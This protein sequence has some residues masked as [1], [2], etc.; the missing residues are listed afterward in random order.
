[1]PISDESMRIVTQSIRLMDHEQLNVVMQAVAARRGTINPLESRWF[2]GDLVEFN[3]RQGR[4]IKGRIK[5]VNQVTVTLEACTDRRGQPA[6]ERGVRVPFSMLRRTVVPVV[7]GTSIDAG[8]QAGRMYRPG[9][10][11][12]AR[13]LETVAHNGMVG[14][15]DGDEDRL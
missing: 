13:V 11:P 2:R 1:M 10:D 8:M 7:A 14:P 15:Q 12:M 4:T 9:G 5:T 3:D 6:F